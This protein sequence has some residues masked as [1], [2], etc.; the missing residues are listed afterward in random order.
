[1]SPGGQVE[2][3]CLFGDTSVQ[4]RHRTRVRAGRHDLHRPRLR[5]AARTVETRPI[6]AA[7]SWRSSP[8]ESIAI[9]WPVQL[10]ERTHAQHMTVDVEGHLV[11]RGVTCGPNGCA[12]GGTTA[13]TLVYSADGSLVK[14]GD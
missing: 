13:T 7:P 9:G 5:L 14:A 3:R 6:L 1:M 4:R 11:V 10:A 8:T 12:D 2:T